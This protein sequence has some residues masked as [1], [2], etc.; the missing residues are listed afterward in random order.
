MD[1]YMFVYTKKKFKEISI[2]KCDINTVISE[3]YDMD[4]QID[5]YKW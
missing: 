3:Y 5:K 1:W 2:L 4:I